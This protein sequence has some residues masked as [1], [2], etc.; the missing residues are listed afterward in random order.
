MKRFIAISLTLFSGVL[1]T[2][3]IVKSN[4]TWENKADHMMRTLTPDV[5][6]SQC[7]QPA[8]DRS[9]GTSRQMYYP[10]DKSVGLIFTFFHTAGELN[11][12]Y[13]SSHIGVPRGKELVPIEDADGTPSWAIIQLPCL[14]KNR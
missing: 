6:I 8:A 2:A 14:E 3:M 5:L 12:A 7:G 13:S 9:S 10:I 1:A 4:Q 11:W